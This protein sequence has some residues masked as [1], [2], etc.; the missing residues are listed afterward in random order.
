MGA[1]AKWHFY[2]DERKQEPESYS[3][4]HTLR[5]CCIFYSW[6]SEREKKKTGM[7]HFY[8]VNYPDETWGKVFWKQARFE[9]VAIHKHDPY[10]WRRGWGTSDWSVPLMQTP[11]QNSSSVNIEV[12][13]F[14]CLWP[15]CFLVSALKLLMVV[16]SQRHT[17]ILMFFVLFN[18]PFRRHS[19]FAIIMFGAFLDIRVAGTFAQ[20]VL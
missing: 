1:K 15:I 11:A 19:L 17:D 18:S 7:A 16:F 12:F 2:P 8:K 20:P 6:V 5:L 9:S 4:H 10:F 3:M 13:C 14:S